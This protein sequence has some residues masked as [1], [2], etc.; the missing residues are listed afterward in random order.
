MVCEEQWECANVICAFH[1]GPPFVKCRP[2]L[3]NCH[4]N[5]IF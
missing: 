1:L 3:F 5:N 4:P 2:E